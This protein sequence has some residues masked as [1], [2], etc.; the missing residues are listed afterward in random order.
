M[1]RRARGGSLARRRFDLTRLCSLVCRLGGWKQL[2]SG[3][4]HGSVAIYKRH[5]GL[6]APVRVNAAWV[7]GVAFYCQEF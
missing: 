1:P 3:V 7:V 6:S 4:G 2:S 5:G